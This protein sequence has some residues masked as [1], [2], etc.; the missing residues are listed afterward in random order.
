MKKLQVL[1]GI[2]SKG[3][4]RK[5]KQKIGNRIRRDVAGGGEAV[6]YLKVR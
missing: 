1:D 6:G 4:A 5:K 3:V 2:F